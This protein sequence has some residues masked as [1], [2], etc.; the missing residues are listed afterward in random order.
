MLNTPMGAL[1]VVVVFVVGNAFVFFVFYLPRTPVPISDPVLVG[2]G[3]IADCTSSGDEATA[4]LLED[5][6]GTVYTLGDNAYESGT[7]SEFSECSSENFSP[8]RA[9]EGLRD[10]GDLRRRPS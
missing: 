2:A 4:N 1:V 3:D 5:V 9:H 10:P 6:S 7:S 8:R